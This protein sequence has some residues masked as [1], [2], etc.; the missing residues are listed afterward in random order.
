MGWRTYLVMYFG[1]NGKAVSEIVKE[2]ESLGF[3]AALGPADF[4]YDWKNKAPT[5]QDVFALADKLTKVLKGSG[6]IFNI[7]THD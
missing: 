5:K 4:L 1:S 2:V 6:V 3:E 7:E